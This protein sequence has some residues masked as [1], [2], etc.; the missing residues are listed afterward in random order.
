MKRK[1]TASALLLG[2][3]GAYLVYLLAQ[4]PLA[5]LA[6]RTPVL[7]KY[8]AAAQLLACFAAV[9]AGGRFASRAAAGLGSMAAA[10]IVSGG[11]T[12]L[13]FL[14][15]FLLYNRTASAGEGIRFL[16]AVL[17]GGVL[18]GIPAKKRRKSAKRKK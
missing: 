7:E 16:L 17:P 13:I 6:V 14:S 15:G 4:F 8:L 5:A 3:S 1:G 11:F 2:M 10:L 12:A 18:A 9:L